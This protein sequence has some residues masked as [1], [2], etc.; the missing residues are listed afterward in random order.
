M[1]SVLM[2]YVK[3]CKFSIKLYNFSCEKQLRMLFIE[4][5]FQQISLLPDIK[6]IWVKMG[7]ECWRQAT[8]MSRIPFFCLARSSN[9][10]CNDSFSSL[11]SV[12]SSAYEV[13]VAINI[14]QFLK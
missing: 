2:L 3:L 13:N 9:G 4:S 6:N 7:E 14:N 12:E 11:K 1:L 5:I 10:K 8:L